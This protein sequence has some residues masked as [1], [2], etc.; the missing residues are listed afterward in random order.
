LRARWCSAYSE[1][2]DFE[3]SSTRYPL[4]AVIR[5]DK[6]VLW[7]WTS[8]IYWPAMAVS[9][10]LGVLFGVLLSRTR[11]MEGPVADLD[12]ALTHGEFRPYF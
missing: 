8:E 5:I 1:T 12:R 3:K 4:R 2:L 11:R 7:A 10:A 9:L 6:S